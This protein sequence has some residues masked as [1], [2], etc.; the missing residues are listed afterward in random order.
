MSAIKL[1]KREKSWI[2]YDVG[3][4]AF[5]LLASTLIP[6]YFSA[7]AD[8]GS[9][10][11]VAWGYATTVASLLLALLMPFLGSIA[12]LKG[13]KKRLL[14][15]SIGT[16]AVLLACMGIP[17]NAMV[18]LVMYVVATIMLNASLVFYDA[19]LIDA[20][21][22]EDRYDEVSS[23][24]YAWG[25]I[26]SCVPFIICLVLVLFGENFGLGQLDAGVGAAVVFAD[27]R[28]DVPVKGNALG[29]H[30]LRD[31]VLRAIEVVGVALIVLVADADHADLQG[32]A[33]GVVAV[34]FGRLR[35]VV[36]AFRRGVVRGV[37]R[38]LIVPAVRTAGGEHAD[39]EH[40]NEKQRKYLLQS[41]FLLDI[42]GSPQCASAKGCP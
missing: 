33:F 40:E 18:F 5:V 13:N 42:V 15:G 17:G 24:G 7:I 8:P 32:L 22:S 38:F 9:S 6:I 3:N 20:T 1:T 27:V 29:G 16:G 11:V 26:G 19:F 37:L 23:Q 39:R 30:L 35:L 31:G 12:D 4:S 10:V 36:A 25:Y 21:D 41:F 28:D 14:V 2:V 34:F